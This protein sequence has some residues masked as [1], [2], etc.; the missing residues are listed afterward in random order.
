MFNCRY[1]FKTVKNN[2]VMS[3]KV[4]VL[5]IRFTTPKL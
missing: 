5:E 1:I 3:E 2:V 4:L